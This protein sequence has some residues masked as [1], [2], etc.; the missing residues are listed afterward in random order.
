MFSVVTNV[1]SLIAQENLR[2]NNE[3][4]SRTIQ[5]LTSGYRINASGDDA[6]GL[7]VANKYRSDIA[8]LTQGVR[9]ANDG[10]SALQ[11]IDG[12]LNNIAKI[13][14]RL[15]TLATQSASGTFTGSRVTLNTE[16]QAL[17]AEINRQASNIGLV[18]GGT[19]NTVL[20]VYIGGGSNQANAKVTVDLSGPLNRVDATS[21]GIGATSVAAGG[22]TLGNVDLNGTTL[23]LAGGSQ[24]FTFNIYDATLG[25]TGTVTVTVTGGASG[26]TGS[27]ALTQLNNA[28]ASY[29]ISATTDANGYL[30]FGGTRAFVAKAQ[31]ASAGTGL[32]AGTAASDNEGVYRLASA[33]FTAVASSAETEVLVFQNAS[34]SVAVTL[35]ET[36]GASVAKAV[37]A[38]NA[39]TAA[40]GIYALE[41]ESSSQITIQSASDFSIVV[42][43]DGSSS[44]GLAAGTGTLTVSEPST[45]ATTTANALAALSAITTAIA[46]LGLVQ[47]RVGTGQNKLQYAIQL[48]QSQIA[49]YSAAESR[50][51]DADMAAEAANLTKAQVMQQA[52]LAAMAQANA[53]PQAV[54]ALLRG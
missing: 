28:L 9:N 53:A 47:G 44:T 1:N 3:F 22:T 36:T 30:A 34:G 2:V 5:R 7:A 13:L 52:S 40:L 19:Y 8:E 54:L 27:A 33:N 50:L 15:K 41:G 4:Q 31:A 16:Y 14:D 20:Q 12:G 49:S 45:S 51:R 42:T 18:E 35:D 39:K 25:Q 29:G 46:N 11:I 24:T 21:L 32:A 23:F 10:I 37:E 48:A 6:A 17:L 38:I 26:I 43:Q